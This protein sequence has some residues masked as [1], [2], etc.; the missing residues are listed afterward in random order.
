MSEPMKVVRLLEP[1]MCLNCRFAQVADVATENGG[2]QRM[3]HC[4]RLD[5][6]NWDMSNAEVAT[7][8]NIRDEAA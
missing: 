2:R 1:E 4:M 8:V 3:I 6:D 7:E 5:C